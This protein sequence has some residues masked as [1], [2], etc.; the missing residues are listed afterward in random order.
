MPRFIHYRR[1]QKFFRLSVTTQCYPVIIAHL[2]DANLFVHR[3]PWK[4][5]VWTIS[6]E[7]SGGRVCGAYKTR[8]LAITSIQ[9]KMHNTTP[10]LFATARRSLIRRIGGPVAHLPLIK[11]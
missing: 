8:Q 9:K 6:E 10:Q 1:N 7:V 3:V 4:H 11:I 2:P 5:S